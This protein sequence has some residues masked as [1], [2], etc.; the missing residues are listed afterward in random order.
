MVNK[1]ITGHMTINFVHS[2]H[3]CILVSPIFGG[4]DIAISRYIELVLCMDFTDG[5]AVKNKNKEP[6]TIRG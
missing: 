4:D 6:T 1:L 3:N 5:K 2:H